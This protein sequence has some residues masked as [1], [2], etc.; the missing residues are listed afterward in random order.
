VASAHAAISELWP[1][2]Y[3]ESYERQRANAAWF[4]NALDDDELRV[5]CTPH[6]TRET[7]ESFVADVKAVTATVAA[8]GG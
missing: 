8:D 3:R 1:D 4:A 5:V 6:V 7:L 2:G